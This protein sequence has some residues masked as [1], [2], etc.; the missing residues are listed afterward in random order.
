MEP[1]RVNEKLTIKQLR[2]E[3]EARQETLTCYNKASKNQLLELL[4]DGTLLLSESPVYKEF[5][6]VKQQIRDEKIKNRE[7][8]QALNED[9][10]R[11]NQIKAYKRKVK[12]EDEIARVE[13]ANRKHREEIRIQR[14]KENEKYYSINFIV[15]GN[16]DLLFTTFGSKSGTK[17]PFVN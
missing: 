11:K 3:C 7:H 13:E 6:K 9:R 15:I 17:L 10:I 2:N 4:V 16:L 12:K 8:S 1:P 5:L 14:I